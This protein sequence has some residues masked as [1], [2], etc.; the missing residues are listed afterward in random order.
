M[1]SLESSGA[2][3]FGLVLPDMWIPELDGEGLVHAIRANAA[4]AKLPVYVIT[5]DVE[6]LAKS[7]AVGFD[8]ILLKP[9]TVEKLREIL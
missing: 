1:A 5:A 9:V 4:L 2:T 6:M 7:E 8:G 3:E